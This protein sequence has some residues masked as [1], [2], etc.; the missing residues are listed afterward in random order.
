[1]LCLITTDTA[2]GG[3]PQPPGCLHD[4]A[5][6]TRTKERRCS[7]GTTHWMGQECA[8][9]LKG[10]RPHNEPTRPV[11]PGRAGSKPMP[12][13]ETGDRVGPLKLKA[14]QVSSSVKC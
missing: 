8:E 4:P 3:L 10:T 6:Q 13:Q 5:L 2:A 12:G 11:R 9:L 7:S 1:M 14:S